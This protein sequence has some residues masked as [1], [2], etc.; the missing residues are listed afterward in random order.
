MLWQYIC[1]SISIY[2]EPCR[3]SSIFNTLHIFLKY[4]PG[5]ITLVLIMQSKWEKYF[6]WRCLEVHN[7]EIGASD[8]ERDSHNLLAYYVAG[9]ML[10]GLHILSYLILTPVPCVGS[11]LSH[12]MAKETDSERTSRYH[13]QRLNPGLEFR[14]V[15]A[16]AHTVFHALFS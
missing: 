12:F 8:G 5:V 13:W 9:I 6:T 16:K 14:P 11:L 10:H 2:W 15:W 3:V 4:S 1:Q 7:L